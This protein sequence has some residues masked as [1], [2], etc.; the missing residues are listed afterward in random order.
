MTVRI[1]RSAQG[2]SGALLWGLLVCGASND[3]ALAQVPVQDAM[4]EQKETSTACAT[5]ASKGFKMN[6]VQ[7]Q[8][9]VKGSV[10]SPGSGGSAASNSTVGQGFAPLVGGG[11]T[12]VPAPVAQLAP[13]IASG[14]PSTFGGN[15]TS[16]LLGSLSQGGQGNAAVLAFGAAVGAF[17]SLN[18]GQNAVAANGQQFQ[19]LS[20]AIGSANG[21]QAGWDQN[22]QVR[23]A[24][25]QTWNQGVGLSLLTA[26]LFNQRLAQ[27]V[28][29]LS[30][31]AAVSS[32][33]PSAASLIAPAPASAP[34]RVALPAVGQPGSTAPA[35]SGT[36]GASAQ[37]APSLCV[38]SSA[39][40]SGVTCAEMEA[41]MAAA[42]AGSS[43]R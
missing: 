11:V 40:P 19:G 12:S 14:L 13:D 3:A 35:S 43:S 18:A 1:L 39:S 31:L 5:T 23:V 26:Q 38:D 10:A 9:G 16:E 21:T 22:S 33:N 7:P 15:T 41:A 28:A 36:A 27:I 8:Q 24:N 2:V 4:R 34:A 37:Q 30:Q 17:A 25:A 29:G 42:Q 20:G 6:Q 32:Y